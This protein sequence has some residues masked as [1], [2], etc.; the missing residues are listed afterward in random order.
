MKSVDNRK[1]FLNGGGQV[2][3]G[4]EFL[5]VFN[6][7]T[8]RAIHAVYY[9]PNRGCFVGGAPEGRFD[10]WGDDYGTRSERYLATVAHLD[11]SQPTQATTSRP[12]L[13]T[14]CPMPPPPASRPTLLP[15]DRVPRLQW[16]STTTT[17][18]EPP[19]LRLLHPAG[20][21]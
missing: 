15:S 18:R 1:E 6:G 14:I 12:T 13:A 19:F 9:N 4:P 16:P 10:I 3:Y 21:C 11:A 5:T 20:M 2:M 17:V 8:G 7:E